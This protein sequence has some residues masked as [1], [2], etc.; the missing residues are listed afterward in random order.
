MSI[1]PSPDQ[2][3][4]QL[5]S[6]SIISFIKKFQVIKLL[7]KCGFRK[8]KGISL[9]S[10]FLYVLSNVFRDRSLYM[11]LKTD[12]FKESFSKKFLLPIYAQ[13]PRQLAPLHHTA[14]CANH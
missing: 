2:Q 5:F 4:E 7:R 12:H 9:F 6:N 1:L 3:N 11:Q 14:F 13:R 10:L 8:E